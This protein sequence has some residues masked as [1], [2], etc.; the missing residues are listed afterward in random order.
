MWLWE[1]MSTVC[2]DTT[3]L[4]RSLLRF[5]FQSIGKSKMIENGWKWGGVGWVRSSMRQLWPLSECWFDQHV[6]S[7]CSVPACAEHCTLRIPAPGSLCSVGEAAISQVTGGNG[8][9]TDNGRP[10]LKESLHGCRQQQWEEPV[11]GCSQGHP[12]YLHQC[13]YVMSE[14]P[15][16]YYKMML[17]C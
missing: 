3:I 16:E 4:T 13:Q 5:S 6:W 17:V 14:I 1:E 12:R 9:G 10:I 15:S 7:P 11:A 8:V 2:T